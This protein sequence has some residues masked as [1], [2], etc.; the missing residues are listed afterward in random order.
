MDYSFENYYQ[1][2]RRFYRFGQKNAVEITRVLGDTEMNILNTI[3]RKA[4][5]KS[6]MQH[7]MAEAMKEFQT[8]NSTAFQL[9]LTEKTYKMP[10]WLKGA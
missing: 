1:A 10:E 6:H 5:M 2:V 8:N 7:S 9:D 3:N 4:S